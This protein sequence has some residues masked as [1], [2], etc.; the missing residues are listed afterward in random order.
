MV[1]RNLQVCTVPEITAVSP[2][3]LEFDA[4][5]GEATVTVSAN[6]G[7]IIP[8]VDNDHFTVSADDDIITVIAPAATKEVLLQSIS[9][10]VMTLSLQKKSL[11]IRQLLKVTMKMMTVMTKAVLQPLLR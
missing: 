7:T 1:P 2:E 4:D 5:G 11:S 10:S 9:R 6:G 8:S 3:S